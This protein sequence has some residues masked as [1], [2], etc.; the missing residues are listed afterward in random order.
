MISHKIIRTK[1]GRKGKR[2]KKEEK[3]QKSRLLVNKKIA[4]MVGVNS[5][6]F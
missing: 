2:G 1:E 3:I 4:N 6:I 5:I